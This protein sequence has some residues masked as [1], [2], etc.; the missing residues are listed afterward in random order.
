[1]V[2]F[3]Y[4][5]F[6]TNILLF[7]TQTASKKKSKNSLKHI[8]GKYKLPKDKKE[9]ADIEIKSIS[10]EKPKQRKMSKALKNQMNRLSEQGNLLWSIDNCLGV[11]G[12]VV[13]VY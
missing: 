11:T 1:M 13:Q 6:C 5:N 3:E 12:F 8:V 2:F 7:R 4:V 10:E 9:A